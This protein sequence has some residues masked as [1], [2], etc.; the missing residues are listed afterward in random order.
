MIGI[1]QCIVSFDDTSLFQA[2]QNHNSNKN[3]FESSYR[4]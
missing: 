3:M 1:H 2:G 4:N